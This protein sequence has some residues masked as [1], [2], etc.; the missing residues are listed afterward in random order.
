MDVRARGCGVG[1]CTRC[2]IAARPF[3]YH[4][5]K[6]RCVGRVVQTALCEVSESTRAGLCKG[7]RVRYL[8][9][10]RR[11]LA[12]TSE[13]EEISGIGETRCIAH[14]SLLGSGSHSL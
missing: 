9:S 5:P 4:I 13:G 10:R 3:G 14:G 1:W 12:Q 8:V 11:E 2:V 6:Y 7:V